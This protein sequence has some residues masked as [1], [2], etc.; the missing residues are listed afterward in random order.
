LEEISSIKEKGA[1]LDSQPPK[2]EKPEEGLPRPSPRVSG[3]E[4][5]P[6]QP[7]SMLKTQ[8]MPKGSTGET[9]NFARK[10][11]RDD[12]DSMNAEGMGTHIK[13]LQL[14]KKRSDQLT[15]SIEALGKLMS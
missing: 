8:N 10:E 2:P 12:L 14:H 3:A 7:H 15:K 1:S 9:H 6:H 13:E 11:S 4:G 5:K